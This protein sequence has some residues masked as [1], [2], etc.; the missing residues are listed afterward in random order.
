[1]DNKVDTYGEPVFAPDYSAALL[2]DKN[3]FTPM[4]LCHPPDVS[5]SPKS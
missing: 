3:V 5:T 1:M 2:A 4:R